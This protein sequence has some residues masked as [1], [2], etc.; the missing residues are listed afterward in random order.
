VV[1]TDLAGT[2]LSVNA[3]YETQTGYNE[4]ELTGRKMWGFTQSKIL[5]AINAEIAA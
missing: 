1:V 3:A 2:L 4:Y 5:D